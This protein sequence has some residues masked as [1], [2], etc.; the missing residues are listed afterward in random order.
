MTERELTFIISAMYAK[1]AAWNEVPSSNVS[2][3]DGAI[4][5]HKG[6]TDL[7]RDLRSWAESL[8]SIIP[9]R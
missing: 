1:A 4:V 6:V 3:Y 5:S 2:G 8:T 7:V 9:D